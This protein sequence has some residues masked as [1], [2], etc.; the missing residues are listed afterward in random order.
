MFQLQQLPGRTTLIDGKEFLFFSGYGYLGVQHIEA[1]LQLVNEGFKKYGWLYPSSRISNTQLT[2]YDEMEILL[3]SITQREDS[4]CFA[5]GFSSGNVASSIFNHHKVFVSPQAHPAINKYKQ[6]PL[7]FDKW[8]EQTLHAIHENSFDKPPVL[9]ADAVN[10]LTSEVGDFDFLQYIEKPLI[11]IIDDSHG[12][13]LLGPNGEGIISQLPKK[14]NI[15]Y[16]FTYSLSKAFSINGGAIS[17]SKKIANFIRTLPEYTSSTPLS[18]A[19]AYAFV[20]GQSVYKKQ[21]EN[22]RINIDCL[23]NLWQNNAAIINDERLPFFVLPNYAD[24]AFFA[25]EN[26]IISSFAYPVAS[27]NKINRIVLNALHKESDL[28]R[29]AKQIINA[30]LRL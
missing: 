11:V 5:S 15:E 9:L 16:I 18:P 4:V 6:A 8:A 13:G 23:R 1:F 24:E 10:P 28:I 19:L 3:S 7:S 2:V 30:E 29:L 27:G 22:L 12:I 20:N 17:C 26:M 25:K 21:R 14:E